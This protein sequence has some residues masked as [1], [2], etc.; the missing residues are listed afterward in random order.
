[1]STRNLDLNNVQFRIAVEAAPNA[2]IMTDEA[3]KIVLV[4]Q[5]AE[6][7]FGYTRSE[8]MGQPIEILVPL[9]YRSQ[10]PTD[11]QKFWSNPAP[12]KMGTGR[13]LFGIR[14]DSSEVPVEIGLTPIK[15]ATGHFVISAIVDITERRQAEM[16]LRKKTEELA[17]SNAELEQ[18]AYIASHDLQAPLRHITSFV[19]LLNKHLEGQLDEKSKQWMGF[20]VDGAQRMQQLINGLLSFSRVNKERASFS[21][22]EADTAINNALASLSTTI[23]D[24]DAKLKVDPLPKIL[25]DATLI[26][27]LFQNLIENAIKFKKPNQSPEVHVFCTEKDNEYVFTVKDNGIGIEK[28]FKDRIFVIFQRLHT[29]EEYPGT[30]MGLAMCKKIVEFHGGKIWLDSEFGNGAYFSFTIPKYQNGI[31]SQ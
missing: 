13:D 16:A 25:G 27:Q 1:M 18:F 7:L 14:K 6:Q 17:R 31:K 12:R 9:R 10:H 5:Q 19:Q 2:M 21:W 3:G 15:L 20:V 11:R 29:A 26:T 30:G 24:S 22:L 8:L 28:E 23:K 4:N